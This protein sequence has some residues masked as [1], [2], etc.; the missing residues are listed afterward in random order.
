MCIT[1]VHV[2]RRSIVALR[3][4]RVYSVLYCH[5]SAPA[6]ALP[7][8]ARALADINSH[9][10]SSL[11]PVR[12]YLSTSP[13]PAAMVDEQTGPRRRRGAAAEDQPA[14]ETTEQPAAEETSAPARP[15]LR[16]A[17]RQF[18]IRSVIMYVIYQYYLKPKTQPK[19]TPNVTEVLTPTDTPSNPLSSML[20]VPTGPVPG[21]YQLKLVNAWAP[22]VPI[23]M[24]IYTSVEAD[25]TFAEMRSLGDDRAAWVL[26]DLSFNTNS[27]NYRLENVTLSVPEN[28]RE[29]NGTWYAHVFVMGGGVYEMQKESVTERM[30]DQYVLYTSRE[31]VSWRKVDMNKEGKSLLYGAEKGGEGEDASENFKVENEKDDESGE[32]NAVSVRFDQVYTPILPIYIVTVDNA[33]FLKQLPENAAKV[34]RV[35][36]E[37]RVYYPPLEVS[38]FWMLRDTFPPMNETVTKTQVEMSL[39]PISMYKWSMLKS[40]ENTWDKQIRMGLMPEEQREDLK[41]MFIETNPILLG[42]TMLVST[43]HTV[44]EALAFKNDISHWK[45]IKSMEGVS[46][47]SMVWKIFMEAIIFLYLWDNNTSWMITIGNGVGIAIAIW[48]LGKAVKFENFGKRRLLGII[49]WFEMN[50]R[51]SYCKETR[52]YDEVAMKY[53]SYAVYPLVLGYALY[54]LKYE[55]HKSWYSWIINSLVGAVYAFGFMM[56]FPQIFI[57]YKLKSVAHMP[58]KAMMYKT[59]NT[60]IDDLFSFIIKMPWLH[61]LACFR[62]DVVFVM[63]LYQRWIY[64]VDKSRV[65]EFGQAFDE[66]GEERVEEAKKEEASEKNDGEKKD[67][68]RKEVEVKEEESTCTEI[69]GAEEKKKD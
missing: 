23:T 68:E 40:F 20:G 63:I 41:R 67:V 42:T 50:D 36:E 31:L 35:S 3:S 56:M 34:F 14:S 2:A 6:R 30:V 58:M 64:P 55:K 47:R 19:V 32:E 18:I 39:S 7:S 38:E 22:H 17:L 27:P 45:N 9:L 21:Y 26:N 10:L 1:F 65:N 12:F 53:L 60:V 8:T 5:K 28:V 54:S 16:D 37:E 62:D 15:P 52:E 46:V 29:R 11:T 57:N 69:K 33:I 24:A 25:M 61:R 43:A 66:N 49:P 44:L 59:L 13:P 48:K 51:E 4:A